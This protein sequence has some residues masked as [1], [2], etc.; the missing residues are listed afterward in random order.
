MI[1]GINEIFLRSADSLFLID[2][3]ILLLGIVLGAAS[4]TG[5]IIAYYKL[6]GR[7]KWQL[8]SRLYASGSI[9]VMIVLIGLH[10][11]FPTYLAFTWLGV[12]LAGISLLYGVLFA[13]PIGGADMP[14]LISILNAVTGVATA[15]SGIVFE[16]SIM[17]LG[18]ILV[19]STGILLT[20]QMCK[21]MN[22]SFLNVLFGAFGQVSEVLV[23]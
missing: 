20:M 12:S 8:N 7:L 9:I 18:G 15:L 2:K 22:R 16:S 1:I 11:I 23:G 10:F 4:F 14:V 17:L 21:A 13:V 19:G 5:S 6:G 3:I